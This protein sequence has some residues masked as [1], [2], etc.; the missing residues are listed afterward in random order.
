[1]AYEPEV[2]YKRVK[3]EMFYISE[4]KER[5]ERTIKNIESRIAFLLE[6]LSNYE[7]YYNDLYTSVY[8][9]SN[10][11][12]EYVS[13]ERSDAQAEISKIRCEIDM[14]EDKLNSLRQVARSRACCGYGW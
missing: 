10:M 13:N 8:G 7:S 11:L 12:Y 14:L 5:N 3:Q 1:M 9:S 2:M 6:R 4:T